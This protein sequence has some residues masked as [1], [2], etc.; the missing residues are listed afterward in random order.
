V[1]LNHIGLWYLGAEAVGFACF[2]DEVLCDEKQE[3]FKQ[4]NV[5]Q[6]GDQKIKELNRRKLNLQLKNV[7]KVYE[8][9]IQQFV[10]SDTDEF[11]DGLRLI[12]RF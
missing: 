9:S 2:N 10:S 6:E 7:A 1:L 12:H 8:G 5:P 4:L 3:M 11:L